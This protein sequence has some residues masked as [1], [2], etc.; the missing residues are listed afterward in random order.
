RRSTPWRV[1]VARMGAARDRASTNRRSRA[2]RQQLFMGLATLESGAV[3]SPS[4]P[5]AP[6]RVLAALD[7][8]IV[9]V[10][11]IAAMSLVM[12]IV[13]TVLVQVVMRYVF[14]KPNPWTEELS[15]FAFIWLSLVG[16]SLATKRGAHFLFEPTVNALP[17]PIQR[18]VQRV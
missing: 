14:A 2:R 15:R 12:V 17:P 3:R 7:R 10:E 13:I 6:R 1:L 16:S 4:G 9:H 5:T 11:T 8:G 18:L